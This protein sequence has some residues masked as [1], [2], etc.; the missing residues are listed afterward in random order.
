MR[1]VDTGSRDPAHA[2]GAWLREIFATEIAEL[3]WQTGFF[4]SDALGLLSEGLGRLVAENALTRVLIGSNDGVTLRDDVWELAQALGVPRANAQVAIVAYAGAFYH[5][6]VCHVRRG[7]HSQAAYV[8]SANLTASGVASLHV[9]AGIVL[10]SRDGDPLDGLDTI[11][12]SVDWWFAGERE[13]DT[14][15]PARRISIDSS[16]SGY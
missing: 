2:L 15:S 8:G 7:D 10:D 9:E 1:Y 11:A 16:R 3:R 12:A 6:K 14:S 13:D 5:P 4:S